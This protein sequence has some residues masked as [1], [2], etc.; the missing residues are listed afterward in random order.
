MNIPNVYAEVTFPDYREPQ[1][2]NYVVFGIVS[3]K[4]EVKQ[5]R[6]GKKYVMLTLTDLQYEIPLAIHGDALE[7]FWKIRPGTMIAVLNPGIY[8]VKNHGEST[9]LG[10]KIT[11]SV[12]VVLEVG[13]AHDL[14]T[15]AAI[16]S[17]GH[18]CTNWVD[19]RRNTYCEFHAELGLKRARAQR[20][21]V[22]AAP[23]K[24][25][26][27]RRNGKR[28]AVYTGGSVSQKQG[29]L[30]DPFAPQYHEGARIYSS[31]G[32]PIGDD[33]DELTPEMQASRLAKRSKTIEREQEIRRML[34]KLP[35]GQLLRE[36]DS[37]GQLVSTTADQPATSGGPPS[38]GR[39]FTPQH[40]RRIGF[41]PTRRREMA[42]D[43]EMPRLSAAQVSLS[44]PPASSTTAADSSDDDLDII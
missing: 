6:V 26:S 31:G 5:S 18:Q 10:L 44:K 30:P 27:P 23:T 29:L 3:R 20:Q 15:C 22:N 24:M 43:R 19:A 7:K 39:L 8:T 11:D 35:G 41:D 13:L 12:D 28:M 9:A 33:Y 21:E 14:G 34:A 17:K 42:K 37:K 4:G 38:P 2:P 25:H 1:Y 36:Y 16:T 32:G 40:V